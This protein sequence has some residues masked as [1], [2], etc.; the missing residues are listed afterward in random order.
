MFPLRIHPEDDKLTRFSE[1][2]ELPAA[3]VQ[4]RH[5]P[6]NFYIMYTGV[7]KGLDQTSF[8][9]RGQTPHGMFLRL[10][11]YQCGI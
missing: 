5:D 8:I 4:S 2:N 10:D 11:I 7:A 6:R 9:I 3:L 1:L